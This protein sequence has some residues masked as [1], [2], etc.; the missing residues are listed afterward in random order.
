MWAVDAFGACGQ[1][2]PSV[3]LP[4]LVAAVRVAAPPV[5]AGSPAAGAPPTSP[6]AVVSPPTTPVAVPSPVLAPWSSEALIGEL[7][8]LGAA[9]RTARL[10]TE[11]GNSSDAD[12][13]A[14]LGSALAVVTQLDL[15][16]RT[17]PTVVRL[18]LRAALSSDPVVR[19]AAVAAA[20]SNGDP[21]LV[22]APS[23]SP[24]TATVAS[25]SNAASA[26]PSASIAAG[27]PAAVVTQVA[28]SS[29]ATAPAAAAAPVGVPGSPPIPAD[30]AKLRE[31][32]QKHLVRGSLQFT[33][34]D[35]GSFVRGANGGGWYSATPV[36]TTVT[37]GVNDGGGA[38]LRAD[39]FAR[40]VADSATLGKLSQETRASRAASL[41]LGVGGGVVALVGI[42]VMAGQEPEPENPGYGSPRYDAYQV[43]KDAVQGRNQGRTLG[44]LVVLT[45]GGVGIAEAFLVPLA[46]ERRHQL[47]HRFYSPTEADRW[48]EG[49]NARLRDSL[50]LSEADVQGIDLRVE[51]EPADPWIAWEV[52]VAPGGLVLAATF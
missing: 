28:P 17:D 32:K 3:A 34:G 27:S 36:T 43:E 5:Q 19:A 42:G 33:T 25:A 8:P 38:P 40:T 18:F 47:I 39:A 11:I 1:A 31:Y 45:A 46:T 24:A 4:S 22:S 2:F 29:V 52:G 50:G 9:R 41:W 21:P 26:P 16:K 51:G 14:A 20:T 15:H 10:A 49:Y 35:G 48:I 6:P 7:L 12:R 37:W 30:P 23:G 44:G 13:I